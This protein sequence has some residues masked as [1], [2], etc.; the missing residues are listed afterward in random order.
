MHYYHSIVP[1]IYGVKKVV[2]DKDICPIVLHNNRVE[3]LPREKILILAIASVENILLFIPLDTWLIFKRLFLK[4]PS[5][6][7][8]D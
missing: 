1:N 8:M 6:Y 3:V 5:L 7:R 4:L 2:N